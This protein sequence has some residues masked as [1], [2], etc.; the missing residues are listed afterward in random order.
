[1]ASWRM[2]KCWGH[3]SSRD[4][5]EKVSQ[6]PLSSAATLKGDLKTAPFYTY[7]AIFV[8][9]WSITDV[10]SATMNDKHLRFKLTAR[11][12]LTK[13]SAAQTFFSCTR[14]GGSRIDVGG[15]WIKWDP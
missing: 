7:F 2:P 15:A 1:M 10:C 6:E 11:N 14:T 3:I 9:R 12:F 4:A 13:R 5:S 8:R